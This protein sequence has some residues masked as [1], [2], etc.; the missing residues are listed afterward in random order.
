[1]FAE[2]KSASLRIAIG[3]IVGFLIGC[4][5]IALLMWLAACTSMINWVNKERPPSRFEHSPE[6][7]RQ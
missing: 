6:E 4:G 7:Y 1:M 5:I 2:I 3:L